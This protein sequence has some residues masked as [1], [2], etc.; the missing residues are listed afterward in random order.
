M[1]AIP[2][3]SLAPHLHKNPRVL[4]CVLCQHR[5]IKCDRNTPCSNCL[6][7]GVT[8]TPSTPAPARKR[9]RPNQD[10]Q[11]RLARCEELLKHYATGG[12]P[13][14]TTSNHPSLSTPSSAAST[15][16]KEVIDTPSSISTESQTT[17][18]P[19]YKII[20]EDGVTRFMDSR[21]WGTV[22]E[23]LQAMR[24]LVE[25]EE[26]EDSSI[27]S[28]E[29]LT[30]DNNTD[31]I[32]SLDFT[33]TTTE[34]LLPDPIHV[35]RLWQVYIDKVNPLSK[36]IHLPTVQP[37][38][39]EITTNT[40][41]VPLDYQA[42]IFSIMSMATL[43]LEE[44]EVIQMLGM[45][46]EKAL[47]TFNAGAKAALIR[48][49]YLKNYN[50]TSLQALMIYLFSLESRIDTHSAWVMSATAV[51]LAQKMGYHHD[52]EK[53]GM[54]PY[55]TEMRRRIW[56][57]LYMHDFKLGMFSGLSQQSSF[58][59]KWDTKVPS[60]LNDAD[61]FPGSTEPVRPRE[62]PTEMI[63]VMI[64]CQV[65]DFKRMSTT[66]D[67]E[68]ELEAAILGQ[69]D[70]SEYDIAKHQAMFNKYRARS[71]IIEEKLIETEEKYCDPSAG[72]AHI[73]ARAFRPLMF[74]NMEEILVPMK[75]Q[76]EWGTEIFGPKDNLFKVMVLGSEHRLSLYQGMNEAGFIW[77]MRITFSID[78]FS[79]LTSQLCTHTRGTLA[80]RGWNAVECTYQ[81]HPE[82][83]DLSQKTRVAQTQLALKAWKA[84]EASYLQAGWPLETP[85]FIQRLR[86]LLPSSDCRSST[87][88]STTA[89]PAMPMM[90]LEMS[91]QPI[92]TGM[93][94]DPFA[95]SFLDMP[96]MSWDMFGDL[97]PAT[98]DQ[99][100]AALYGNYG[101]GNLN[102]NNLNGMGRR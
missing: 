52:G 74:K 79:F 102:M 11:E 50:M 58:N 100:P 1:S 12:S 43:S 35:F 42:L 44:S 88:N 21:I 24:S 91:Q 54:T 53:L 73:A 9:R 77:F 65:F 46:R 13:P 30:P 57:Q 68:A 87:A 60:N 5:K 14:S 61:L 6:K 92:Q 51:R 64:M 71:R 10:L 2:P 48:F 99:I 4:A 67:E 72:N 63:F 25:A 28:P 41:N 97:I 20:Q 80:D 86:E 94:T 78:F 38:V 83:F 32:L 75:D 29:E 31:L 7:A 26:P 76:P 8:C 90:G 19:R 95:G 62:G 36:T 37:Y 98:S 59:M 66:V 49:N 69:S 101:L 16:K 45:T 84:R 3:P 22:V 89:T 96:P 18:Q 39:V 47:Q 15:T 17:I 27:L 82:L 70:E 55:E 56:W 40:S 34:D 85:R 93:E 81:Y 33:N 23:E